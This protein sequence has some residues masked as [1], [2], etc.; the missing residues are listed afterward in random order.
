MIPTRQA[1]DAYE[2][3]LNGDIQSTA[4]IYLVY[5]DGELRMCDYYIFRDTYKD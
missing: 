2:S 4:V 5:K 3:V 1:E